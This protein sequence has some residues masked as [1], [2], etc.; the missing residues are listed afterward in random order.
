MSDLVAAVKLFCPKDEVQEIRILTDQG[1]MSGF[2]DERQTMA[3][4]ILDFDTSPEVKAIYWVLNPI[5]R[6]TLKFVN[7]E[8]NPRPK[9]A[10]RTNNIAKRRWLLIDIDPIRAS[11]TNATDPEKAEARVVADK[12]L[13]FLTNIGWP[14]PIRVDSG[15]GYHLLYQIDRPTLDI[16]TIKN[17]LNILAWKFNTLG[18]E[19]DESVHDA[20][21]ICKVPGTWSRKGPHSAIRP[22]RKSFLMSVPAKQ[23]VVTS[24][25][26]FS[27]YSYAPPITQK[28]RL[29]LQ[30]GQNRVDEFFT[31]Y[32]DVLCVDSTGVKDGAT[33]YYLSECPF[34][35]G[36]HR[37]QE[38]GK[39]AI[40]HGDD[41]GFKCFSSD[42]EDY[43]MSDLLELLEDETG[44]PFQ[45]FS[46]DEMEAKWGG[47]EVAA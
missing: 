26:L 11:G 47:I 7:N 41:L 44:I 15:N 22:H 36:A 27:V 3:R 9:F 30:V 42:C 25:L 31:T 21:R 40:I 32:E 13:E 1:M 24:N 35:E 10:T 20:V 34:N 37:G 18:A 45:F 16:R 8:I 29:R 38:N 43:H 12:V 4:M 5:D 39:T 14:Q 23:E 33:Y 19:V 2:Y 46:Q 28:S 6:K 17:V